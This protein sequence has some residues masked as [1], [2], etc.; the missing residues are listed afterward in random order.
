VP[1]A[2]QPPQVQVAL[3]PI[4]VDDDGEAGIFQIQV[5][6]TDP[7]DS[8]PHVLTILKLPSSARE[9]KVKLKE[10]RK[11][12]I[13]FTGKDLDIK[14]PNPQAFLDQIAAYGGIIVE[15]GQ[16]IDLR[17]KKKDEGKLQW[18]DGGWRLEAQTIEL[19]VIATDAAGLS[20][21]AQVSSCLD[22]DCPTVNQE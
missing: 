22:K 11:T 6:A 10:N 21:S 7:E 14:A 8:S 1:P 20:S 12:E 18:E 19:E 5:T 17:V 4:D 2:N 3:V 16:Q 9:R 13:K 15:N